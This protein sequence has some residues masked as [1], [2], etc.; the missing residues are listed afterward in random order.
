[1]AYASRT[2]SLGGFGDMEN[3][4]QATAAI[5]VL[6]EGT[7]APT[8]GA[9]ASYTMTNPEARRL[10]CIHLGA[11]TP[12]AGDIR[13]RMGATA[14]ATSMPLIPQKYATF[15]LAGPYTNGS[16]TVAGEFVSFWNTGADT[17]TVYCYEIM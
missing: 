4:S 17:V 10:L 2:H 11:S 14:T 16:T 7:A 15:E 3:A 6:A 5:R 13:F 12:A 8:T 9:S 1:M